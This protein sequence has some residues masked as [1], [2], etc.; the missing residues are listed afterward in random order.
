[1]P[2]TIVL[3]KS[4]AKTAQCDGSARTPYSSTPTTSSN[5]PTKKNFLFFLSFFLLFFFSKQTPS[6][7][8]NPTNH[9][10]HIPDPSSFTVLPPNSFGMK[11]PARVP[12]TCPQES[13]RKRER[14]RKLINM[15]DAAILLTPGWY[16]KHVR[17]LWDGDD[18]TVVYWNLCVMYKNLASH[19][20]NCLNIALLDFKC[21]T[22]HAR[23]TRLY[24]S[25]LSIQ[26]N[27]FQKTE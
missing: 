20:G 23:H 14:H 4:G 9:H 25:Y 27:W 24:L 17:H 21:F 11:D 15:S 10:C 6:P 16:S 13:Q 22:E 5:K 3:V 12:P 18:H 8:P 26:F 19:D 7:S 1:M 2:G